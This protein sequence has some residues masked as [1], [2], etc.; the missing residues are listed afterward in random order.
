LG[1]CFVENSLVNQ[2]NVRDK[3]GVH[4]V[5]NTLQ[6]LYHFL[7]VPNAITA[8]EKIKNLMKNINL[9]TTL[10]DFGIEQNIIDTL[11]DEVNVERLENNPVLF[12]RDTIRMI[13]QS[14]W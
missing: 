12:T 7:Q 9:K 11:V 10:R 3:R 6:K 1:S 4:Y 2:D 8:Q 5:Q 14:I 13:Y